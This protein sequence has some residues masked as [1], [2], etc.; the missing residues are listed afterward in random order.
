MKWLQVSLQLDGE[1]T[2]AVA[3]LLAR[4][5]TGGVSIETTR[6]E[7]PTQNQAKPAGPFLVRAFLP[8]DRDLERRRRKLAEGLWH[9]GQILPLPEPHYRWLE[10]EDWSQTWKDRY[11]PLPVG[12]N[13]II[14]PAWLKGIAG[15][16][17]EI[18]LDPGMAFGTGTHPST[19]LCLEALED[20]LRPGDAVLDIG[21]GSGILSI[22]AAL[23]GARSVL[24]MDTDADAVEAARQNVLRN[25]V[26]DRVQVLPG[27]LR[28]A[29]EKIKHDPP[30]LI[31]ANILAPTLESL[32]HGGLGG[33]LGTDGCLILSG[34]LEDQSRALTKQARGLGLALMEV[35]CEQDWHA[36]ILKKGT[37]RTF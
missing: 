28:Q 4:Y 37:G 13:L 22:A 33:L 5:A 29:R 18:V 16:R 25:K 26:S 1:R 30:N 20:H 12:R 24:S 9:L 15:P 36:L 10:E 17:T 31:L 6:I 3:E 14:V 11:R 19:R 2:E 8:A 27:S 32:L 23:L 35:R 21:T 34:I 7:Q